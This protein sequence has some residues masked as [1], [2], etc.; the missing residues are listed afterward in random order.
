M[1]VLSIAA[2]EV[3]SDV[4]LMETQYKVL[5]VIGNLVVIAASL[6]VLVCPHCLFSNNKNI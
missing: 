3:L 1:Q 6:E 2:Y 5:K 4:L